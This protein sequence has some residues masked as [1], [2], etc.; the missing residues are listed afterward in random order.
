MSAL[1]V[2]SEGGFRWAAGKLC[3]GADGAAGTAVR[4]RAA[5]SVGSEAV[6]NGRY[7]GEFHNFPVPLFLEATRVAF[8]YTHTLHL[9]GF[10][11][12]LFRRC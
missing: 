12:R 6:R 10:G 8:Q 5:H 11:H 4:G 3:L 2:T 7:T 9:T 1:P